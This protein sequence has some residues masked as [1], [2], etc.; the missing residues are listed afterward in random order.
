MERNQDSKNQKSKKRSYLPWFLFIS[1]LLHLLFMGVFFKFGFQKR[2]AS[3]WNALST[4]IT[5]QQREKFKLESKQRREE[6]LKNLGQLKK[7]LDHT[8]KDSLPAK[9]TAPKSNFG[10]V[11]YDSPPK[12]P[13][14][15]QVPTTLEGPIG[16]AEVEHA[17]EEKPVAT[18]QKALLAE[19]EQA[20]IDQ[21]IEQ[22]KKSASSDAQSKKEEKPNSNNITAL[23]ELLPESSS[24]TKQAMAETQNQRSDIEK[25]IAQI[26]ALQEKLATTPVAG[27][28]KPSSAQIDKDAKTSTILVRGAQAEDGKPK[29]SIIALTKGFIE[30]WEGE[31][32]N[33]L[34]DRNGDPN[35][36][37]GLE[38]M[39]YLSYESKIT[40][41]LQ[42]AWKQNFSYRRSAKVFEGDA[43]VEFCIDEHGTLANC[44]L[45]QSSGYPELDE[46]ILK[47]MRLASPFPPLP[48]HFG[49]K[50]YKTGRIIQVRSDRL[51]F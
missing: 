47:N 30:K 31:D 50:L 19:N 18:P 6:L 10:W 11:M 51:K 8:K 16:E 5:P 2:I 26:K 48:K 45:L 39:R 3:W 25:T 12:P 43:I 4:D 1:V 41:T 9:L 21:Q 44:N 24:A 34:I 33:D 28:S 46:M 42:A 32:G 38:E 40:W 15:V 37:P 7:V 17:T 27:A 14:M 29:R 23:K 49:T 35:R 36:R 22:D 13:E 20:K